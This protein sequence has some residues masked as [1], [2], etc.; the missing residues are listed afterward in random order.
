[1]PEVLSKISL[2]RQAAPSLHISVDG[3]INGETGR[4]VKEAGADMLVAGS[5]VFGA[6]DPAAAI[7]SL[8]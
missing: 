7:A 2:L 3:G 6:A 8:R 1:M 5:Y 4:L